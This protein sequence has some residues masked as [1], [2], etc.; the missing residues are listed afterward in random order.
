MSNQTTTQITVGLVGFGEVGQIF[1]EDLVKAGVK[2]VQA[3]DKLFENSDSQPLSAAK[4]LGVVVAEN[5]VDAAT[6]AD[7]VICAVTAANDL[8][9]AQAAAP[10][11]KKNAFYLDVNSASPAM[12][13]SAAQAIEDG[14]GRYVEAAVM[15]PAPPKRLASPMLIGGSHMNAFISF[16]QPL[17]FTG[18]DA[19]SETLGQASATKMCRSVIVKGMETLLTESMLSARHYG[20]QDVVLKSLGDLFPLGNWETLAHYMISRSIEHGTRKAEEMQEVARTVSE[21]G[22]E[23]LMATASSKREAWAP[24]HMA[25]LE[26]QTLE[27]LLDAMLNANKDK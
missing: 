21:A 22:I 24:Q 6:G 12:K 9:A 27:P 3:Y 5:A 11:I 1:G 19:F 18:L 2:Q 23:P 7:L 4:Q 17:G 14:G 20:V 16:A 26:H 8:V 15:S 10:G 25:A 13:Q